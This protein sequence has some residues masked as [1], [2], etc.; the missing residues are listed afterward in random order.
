ML[1][2][3]QYF[4][5]EQVSAL[6]TKAQASSDKRG[7]I[8][9]INLP[10]CSPPNKPPPNDKPEK[11]EFDTDSPCKLSLSIPV[12]RG[13]IKMSLCIVGIIYAALKPCYTSTNNIYDYIRCI[14]A[15][16]LQAVMNSEDVQKT[17]KDPRLL[18]I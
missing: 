17:F 11:W 10:P 14:K 12:L 18:Y 6:L 16:V 3:W 13:K 4:N 5:E 8:T 15:T 7:R 1:G 2:G 9:I